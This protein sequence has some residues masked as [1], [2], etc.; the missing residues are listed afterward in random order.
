MKKT[1][2]KAA[3][4]KY[5]LDQT[6]P[7]MLAKGKGII[8][9]KI[10]GVGIE[11]DIPI[12]EDPNLVESLLQMDLGEYIP[13][14]LYEIVAEILIFIQDLDT[15]KIAQDKVNINEKSSFRR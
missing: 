9:E 5:N 3:A 1:V 8:A 4:L 10:L 14:E 15:L 13:P 7:Q 11:Q 2:K 12:Y 6:A